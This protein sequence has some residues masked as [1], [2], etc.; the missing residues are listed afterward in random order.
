MGWV[1]RPA[2]A[3][4]AIFIALGVAWAAP[5][6]A[7]GGKIGPALSAHEYVTLEPFVLPILEG[8]GDRLGRKQYTIVLALKL[9]DE[10]A[11]EEVV[12]RT[13]RIRDALYPHLY[14]MLTFN[15]RKT[16][17]SVKARLE[18][19]L[20]PIALETAGRDL[21]TALIVH[22]AFEGPRP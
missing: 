21:V 3:V 13:P 15:S 8:K 14:R 22:K 12:R 6:L 7:Q 16:R 10:D 11:R 18:D 4:L 1:I 5:A 9:A 19:K 2:G 20:G 17:V